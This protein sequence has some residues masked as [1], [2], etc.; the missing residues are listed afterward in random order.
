MCASWEAQFSDNRATESVWVSTPFGALCSAYSED[1]KTYISISTLFVTY[2]Q[3]FWLRWF[4]GDESLWSF[5]RVVRRVQVNRA[6]NVDHAA[7]TYEMF[8][9]SI[10][11]TTR[12]YDYSTWATHFLRNL[13]RAQRFV[14][15]FF[16]MVLFECWLAE[17]TSSGHMG[18]TT[19]KLY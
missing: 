13:P 1:S 14:G 10:V 19:F 11:K 17:H 8:A 18:I 6:R 2:D 12:W 4:V 15:F 5:A 16:L 9:Y 7:R 3:I